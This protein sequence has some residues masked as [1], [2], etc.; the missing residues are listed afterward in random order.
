MLRRVALVVLT[1]ATWP[2]SQQTAFFI[3]TATKISNL[4]YFHGAF[5]V[6]KKLWESGMLSQGD[7]FEG[8]GDQNW[9]SFL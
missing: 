8:D 3:V 2:T 9:V 1:R 5:E 4:T 7:Y 6:L